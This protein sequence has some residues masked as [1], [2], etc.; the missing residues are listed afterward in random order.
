MLTWRY[1]I[2]QDKTGRHIPEMRNL[3]TLF[4]WVTVPQYLESFDRGLE[5]FTQSHSQEMIAWHKQ[6]ESRKEKIIEVK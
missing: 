5:R 6:N 3:T 2:R 1:R 4:F